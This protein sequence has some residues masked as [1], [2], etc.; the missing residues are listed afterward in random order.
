M[1]P[2]G[3]RYTRSTHHP[4]QSLDALVAMQRGDTRYGSSV[5]HIFVDTVLTRCKCGDLRSMCHTE[6]LIAHRKFFQLLADG[7]RC[8][9]ANTGIDLIKDEGFLR[10]VDC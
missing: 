8:L 1:F 10:P 2:C 6:D 9:A 7:L 5:K 3:M 4:H